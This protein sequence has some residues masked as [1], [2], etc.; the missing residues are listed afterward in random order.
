MVIYNI[1]IHCAHLKRKIDICL[2]ENNSQTEVSPVE[3]K[4]KKHHHNHLIN[5]EYFL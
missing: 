3:I 1:N 4:E 2:K 5:V